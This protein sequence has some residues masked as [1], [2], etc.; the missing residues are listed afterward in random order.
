MEVSTI[1]CKTTI[2]ERA[3][4]SHSNLNNY[5]LLFFLPGFEPWSATDWVWVY[6]ADDIPMSRCASVHWV[7]VTP[8]LRDYSFYTH[9]H[10]N[11]MSWLCLKCTMR[12]QKREWLFQSFKV[13]AANKII[14]NFDCGSMAAW[15]QPLKN[16]N[17]FNT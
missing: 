17:P 7:K 3:V 2:Y 15:P 10:D 9:S 16:P 6:E 1:K 8:G 12:S 4:N 13:V 14:A 11:A 5:K